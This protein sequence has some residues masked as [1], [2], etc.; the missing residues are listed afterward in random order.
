MGRRKKGI[1]ERWE[2]IDILVG[3]C[4]FR[5]ILGGPWGWRG[6]GTKSP[7]RASGMDPWAT[8]WLATGGSPAHES[9]SRRVRRDSLVLSWLCV[10]S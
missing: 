1:E 10:E 2:G 4:P 7:E 3:N 8:M 9:V 5:W 6:E